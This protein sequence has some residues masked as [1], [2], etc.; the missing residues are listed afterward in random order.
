M[1]DIFDSTIERFFLDMV[2]TDQVLHAESEGWHEALWGS[3]DELGFTFAMAPESAG[4]AGASWTDLCGVARLTGSYSLPLPLLESIFA[5]W[6]LSQCEL[7]PLTGALSFAAKS[8]LKLSEGKFT[9]VLQDVPWGRYAGHILAIVTETGQN[10]V[11]VFTSEQIE[12]VERANNVAGEARDTLTFAQVKPA[13]CAV[14]PPQLPANILLQGGAMMRSAQIAGALHKA[15][16]ISHEYAA[17]R[18]QFGRPIGSFQA[19]QHQLA[20]MAEHVTASVIS[21]EA[22]FSGEPDALDPLAVCAAKICT[23]EAAG[24]GAS[25][26]H[27]VH[28]AIGFTHE[29]P[30]HLLSRRLWSWRS[31]FGSETYWAK[32]LG[33][34][35]C[36]QGAQDFWPAVTAGHFDTFQKEI[37]E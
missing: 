28:G 19:I 36:K 23:S 7:A 33:E 17:E 20:Q 6:L 8:D 15:M 10:R 24:I 13:F 30:L 3:L 14:L 11:V 25:I 12:S 37:R 32:Q 9:G 5:N 1:R 22:A 2:S 27:A 4:G 21:A 29:H 31:E 18:V 16:K 34:A 35:V 26:A